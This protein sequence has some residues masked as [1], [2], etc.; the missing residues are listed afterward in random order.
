MRVAWTHFIVIAAA[1]AAGP[2]FAQSS[3]GMNGGSSMPGM[4]GG[5]APIQAQANR[6]LMDAMTKMDRGMNAAKP[7][8]NA[9]QDFVAMMIPHH[10]GA[11][12]M[13]E[14]ELKYGKDP[15]LRRLA[16]NI[17]SA[18]QKEIKQMRGWQSRHPATQ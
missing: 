7:T 8:G 11:I 18:Q 12:D 15:T 5:A 4:S 1:C 3:P 13:A 10:Q 9:D 16:R 6:D 17:I 14:A 2:A